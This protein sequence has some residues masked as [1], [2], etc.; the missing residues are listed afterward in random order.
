MKVQAIA[1]SGGLWLPWHSNLPEGSRVELDVVEGMP[2]DKVVKNQLTS[3]ETLPVIVTTPTTLL[4][5]NSVDVQTLDRLLDTLYGTVKYTASDKS[6]K[7]L[8][9]ER[10]IEKHG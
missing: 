4:T 3:P 6:D 1:K 2:G 5:E 9:H 7:E 8:W 10:M